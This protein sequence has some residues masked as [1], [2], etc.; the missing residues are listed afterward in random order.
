MHDKDIL[1]VLSLFQKILLLIT[2]NSEI[3]HWGVG[4]YIRNNY[5]YNDE[6]LMDYEVDPDEV[7]DMII[8]KLIN[9]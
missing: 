9:R 2:K 1:L 4:I 7:S 8:K 5:I 3:H 6:Y